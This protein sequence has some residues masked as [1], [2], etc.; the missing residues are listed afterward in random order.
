MLA[1]N[2]LRAAFVGVLAVLVLS[3]R[4]ELGQIYLLAA[5]F[6]IVDAFFWPALSPSSPCS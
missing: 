1:S 5:I 3:G 6:G 2:A 4:A